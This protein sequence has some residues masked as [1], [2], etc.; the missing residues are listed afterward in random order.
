[1]WGRRTC[2]CL[3]LHVTTG[4][5]EHLRTSA[6]ELVAGDI[7]L[8]QCDNGGKCYNNNKCL[9]AEANLPHQGNPSVRVNT[10]FP[11]DLRFQW[12]VLSSPTAGYVRL[13]NRQT[14]GCMEASSDR[15]LFTRACDYGNGLQAWKNNPMSWAGG[16]F[17]VAA[18]S[19]QVV[20][21]YNTDVVDGNFV[22]TWHA[23]PNFDS[24]SMSQDWGLF[25]LPAIA[26]CNVPVTSSAGGNT[27]YSARVELGKTSGVFRFTYNTYDIKDRMVVRYQGTVLHDTG[28]VGT[29]S[30]TA[31]NLSYSGS[32]AHAIVEVY[33]NCEGTSGTAWDFVVSCP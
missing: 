3:C 6:Q 21:A 16:D 31:L 15:V 30:A 1:S 4:S 14:A 8:I 19:Q 32:D 9:Y 33:P 2:S 18:A 13:Q 25:K 26:Q 7:V 20:T 10:C 27:A 22:H 24:L 23:S 17:L 29:S 12:V 5:G 11:N 28:C